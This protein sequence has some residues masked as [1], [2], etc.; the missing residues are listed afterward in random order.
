M[1]LENK[2]ILIISPE[3]WGTNFVS[4][5]H[6]ANYLSDSNDVF[7][8]NPPSPWSPRNVIKRILKR[9]SIQSRLTIINHPFI[10]PK[11]NLLPKS[12]QNWLFK[13]QAREIQ[14]QLN[15]KQFDIIWSFTPLLYWDLKV[16]KSIKYLYHTVDFHPHAQFEHLTCKSADAVVGIADLIINPLRSFN[17]RVFKIGHGADINGF[18]NSVA[19][20]QLGHPEKTQ[21]GYI[22]NFHNNIDYDLLL[23][24]AKEHTE[25]E[26]QL[27]G[28]YENSNLSDRNTTKPPAFQ[29]LFDLEH[30]HFVGPVPSNELIGYMNQ[31]DINLVLFK[32][33][34]RKIHCNPHKMMGYFYS[35]KIIVS[36]YIDEYK[37]NRE[38]LSMVDSNDEISQIFKDTLNN[39]SSLNKE[40]FMNARKAYA[41]NN[42]YAHRIDQ[43][44]KLVELS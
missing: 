5:H 11:I 3:Q 44:T 43:I 23:K 13:K 34:K 30:V 2:K 7:F 22:G 21:I 35:G 17:E 9:E 16:W 25:V 32:D 28:P 39:L 20:P 12:L 36:S 31:F 4:K 10:L 41:L 19:T 29:T 38:L 8:L 26:F 24:I 1:R 15:I 18:E 27:I 40:E 6:Y 37:D 42:S 33:E 14:A